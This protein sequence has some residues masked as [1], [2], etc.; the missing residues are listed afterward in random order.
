MARHTAIVAG[1]GL[2]FTTV[3]VE[4]RHAVLLHSPEPVEPFVAAAS[5]V[6]AEAL[7]PAHEGL[8]AALVALRHA[9]TAPGHALAG[10]LTDE[11]AGAVGLAPGV[12]PP[13]D[14]GAEA[15]EAARS[16]G[17]AVGV[18]RGRA[19][20]VEEAAGAPGF[21]EIGLGAVGVATHLATVPVT[22]AVLVE[23]AMG[24]ALA[25]IVSGTVRVA[26]DAALPP[27][28]AE[29]R[30]AAPLLLTPGAGLAAVVVPGL[31]RGR[32]MLA[33][34]IVV[35]LA[36]LEPAAPSVVPARRGASAVHV[37]YEDAAPPGGGFA[38]PLI[39]ERILTLAVGI[40]GLGLH[41]QAATDGVVGAL[42]RDS[43]EA[44]PA[45]PLILLADL[46][47]A[48]LGADAV[49]LT[50]AA[51]LIEAPTDGL[52]SLPPPAELHDQG[53]L[54]LVQATLGRLTMGRLGG[55]AADS[56]GFVAA[57]AAAVLI[58]GVLA[59]LAFPASSLRFALRLRHNRARSVGRTGD[60]VDPLLAGAGDADI[61][62]GSATALAIGPLPRLIA[63]ALAGGSP[64][65]ALGA[66]GRR[67]ANAPTSPT[68][69][70]APSA[71][72][73][74][75]AGQ[76]KDQRERGVLHEVHLGG[77]GLRRCSQKPGSTTKAQPT[78]AA[79]PES[80]GPHTR[81]SRDLLLTARP[82]Y[83]RRGDDEA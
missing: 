55:V 25:H 39:A 1:A 38:E 30:C 17:S 12:A 83:S 10:A 34:L 79:Q 57:D 11:G 56:I 41:G 26:A 36:G 19:L 42:I 6:C 32:P 9:P 15:P 24:L 54:P 22:R 14:D 8:R 80:A 67:S 72:I 20:P 28:M 65:I 63:P 71:F 76:Q 70:A 2:R 77:T 69:A 35:Y 16:G 60:A 5:A 62:A 49:S 7:G 43:R 78:T 4:G 37:A 18:S 44:F 51:R 33:P 13:V 61:G 66:V 46:A 29:D 68:T 52:A 73:G 50:I 58:A 27:D 47:L 3:V 59:G 64:A 31:A 48:S 21:A 81:Q 82:T 45:T 23:G 40:G 74:A 53:A 75:G